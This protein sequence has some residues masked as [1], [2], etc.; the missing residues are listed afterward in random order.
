MY[1]H[2]DEFK[3]TKIEMR[4]FIKMESLAL[5]MNEYENKKYNPSRS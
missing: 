3:K 4:V 2:A 1:V 5:K